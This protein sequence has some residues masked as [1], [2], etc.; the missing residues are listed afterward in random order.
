MLPLKPLRAISWRLSLNWI[1][2]LPSVNAEHG[3]TKEREGERLRDREVHVV[4]LRGVVTTPVTSPFTTARSCGATDDEGTLTREDLK[5]TLVCSV[6][7]LMA[8]NVVDIIL[9]YTV[10]VCCIG[11]DSVHCEIIL[12]VV[13]DIRWVVDVPDA[14]R[15]CGTEKHS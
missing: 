9:G 14:W 8:K 1:C 4:P 6:D 10:L 15:G 7:D 13:D 3:N 5:E 2:H 11:A 12:N